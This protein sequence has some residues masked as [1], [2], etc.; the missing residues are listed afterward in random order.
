MSQR[1]FTADLH[2]GHEKVAHLRGFETVEEHDNT[3]LASLG[4]NVRTTDEL[5][6]L[7]DISSGKP[8]EEDEALRRLF[9][10]DVGI[11]HLISG[12]HD[13]VS[14]THRNGWKHQRRFLQVF[15]SV[16]ENATIRV[17]GRNVMLSHYPY[18]SM[19]DGPKRGEPRYLQHRLPDIGAPLI[20]GHTH[21]TVATYAQWPNQFC[22]SWDGHRGPV[23]IKTIER[24]VESL[25]V[26]A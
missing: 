16:R 19:G 1:W 9:R 21:D 20:H 2:L 25:E 17:A 18:A 13:S 8:D 26:G 23:P 6:V 22:V 4:A 10:L 24:W 3:V 11:I 15:E 14:T 5:F 12:N 7:G